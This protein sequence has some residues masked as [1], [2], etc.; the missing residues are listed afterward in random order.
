M[1]D[2][3]GQKGWDLVIE[4]LAEWLP[5]EDVQWVILGTGD[6]RYA[7]A[8]QRLAAEFPSKISAQ[9]TFSNELSHQIEAAADIF[10]MPSRY[11]PCGLNQLYSLKYG[12]IPVVHATGGLVDTI[13]DTNQQTLIEGRATG[14][15]FDF[16]WLQVD[17][18]HG[19]GTPFHKRGISAEQGIYFLGLPKL[20]N[21]ASSFIYGCWYDAKYLATHIGV[22]RSYVA[23]E[24]SRPAHSQDPRR[25][26][27]TARRSGAP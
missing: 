24:K 23:Y 1:T 25:A 9:L 16:N 2:V 10:L 3:T 13:T 6:D 12:T 26:P 19:D 14:F 5:T 21:R 11:E 15:K 18:F 20:T 27:P 7:D 22:Q 4:T 17:A 8:L